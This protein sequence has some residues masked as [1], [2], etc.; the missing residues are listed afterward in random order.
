MDHVFSEEERGA[1]GRRDL[2][3]DRADT[4]SVVLDFFSFLG[5]VRCGVGEWWWEGNRV[6]AW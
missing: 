5:V 3:L 6:R 4:V 1:D 2:K